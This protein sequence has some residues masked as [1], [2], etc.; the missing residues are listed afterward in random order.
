MTKTSEANGVGGAAVSRATTE[1][2]RFAAANAGE[3]RRYRR[4]RAADA[5]A[6]LVHSQAQTRRQGPAAVI[7]RMAAFIIERSAESGACTEGELRRA[8]FSD[9]D[10]KHLPAAVRA[11]AQ[12]APGLQGG[13]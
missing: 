9:E 13:C 8:G 1:T 2:S 10:L 5:E 3:A 6:A 4:H 7:A 12:G 11:A